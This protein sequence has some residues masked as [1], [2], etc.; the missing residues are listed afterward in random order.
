MFELDPKPL[1]IEV[2]VLPGTTLML[3]AALVEPLRAANRVLGRLMYSWQVTSV[4]GGKVM[5]ASGVPIPVVGTFMP[6]GAL[7]LFVTSSYGVHRHVTGPLRHAIAQAGRTRPIVAGMEAG[8]WLL[9]HAGVLDGHKATTHWEDLTAF[10]ARFPEIDTIEAPIV[11]DR[12]RI[13]TAGAVPTMNL[14]LDLIA[15][16]QGPA[17]AR[18][19]ARLLNYAPPPARTA[20]RLHDTQV[21][22]AVDLMERNLDE[23]IRIREI[24]RQTALSA[25]HLQAR[26]RAALGTSPRA[27]YIGL[28]LH[29]ARRLLI[30]TDMAVLEVAAATGFASPSAFSRAY[31]RQHGETPSATRMPVS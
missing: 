26:F 3:F 17:R 14:M 30:E 7:P 18:D 31:A 25:R 20:G 13:T 28:R 22:R 19:V 11:H 15:H 1:E 27:H 4:G 21:A 29:E 10:A 5:T 2:L 8:G 16:R 12:N 24:A 9:A 23:P 6:G